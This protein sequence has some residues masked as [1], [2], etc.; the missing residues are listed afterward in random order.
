[1]RRC[2]RVVKIP[3]YNPM[4]E[5]ESIRGRHSCF[6]DQFDSVVE[7]LCVIRSPTR[8]DLPKSIVI[9]RNIDLKKSELMI[10]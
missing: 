4:I 7:R 9:V 6:N 2:V 3:F 5:S 1:M 8:W 10:R